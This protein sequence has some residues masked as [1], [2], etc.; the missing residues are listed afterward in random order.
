[1]VLFGSG[2]RARRGGGHCCRLLAGR[3]DRDKHN[4]ICAT[5]VAVK[6]S[7]KRY[8][9]PESGYASYMLAAH[10]ELPNSIPLTVPKPLKK[11]KP[12]APSTT[13]SPGETLYH[14]L[15]RQLSVISESICP[16]HP[17]P[18]HKDLVC[19]PPEPQQA[20]SL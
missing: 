8:D 4:E 9:N 11:L 19:P 6:E 16:E 2:R 14:R 13:Q 7:V 12:P 17:R 20:R 18:G 3:K 15:I 10:G 1:M 5:N